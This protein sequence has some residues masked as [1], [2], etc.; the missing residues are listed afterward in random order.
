MSN[1]LLLL[2][3][4]SP[5]KIGRDILDKVAFVGT[6]YSA[7]AVNF[8][9][10]SLYENLNGVDTVIVYGPDL[11]GAGDLI[12]QALRGVCNEAVRVPCK[13]VENLGVRVVDLRWSSEDRLRRAVEELYKP[14]ASEVRPRVEIQLEV[15][16]KRMP[17]Q[18]PHIL[19]DSDLEALRYKAVDYLLTY[20]LDSGDVIYGVLI[21]QV[22]STGSYLMRPCDVL[23]EWPCGLEKSAFLIA[24][25]AFVQ[26]RGL[27]AFYT[28]KPEI[29]KR[30]VYDPHGNFVIADRLYHY[31]PR[32][33]LLRQLELDEANL[34]KEAQKLLP[35]HAFYLGQEWA[36]YKILRDRYVQDRWKTAGAGGGI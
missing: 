18:G 13:Y 28:A 26:K 16:N 29:Y 5:D 17:Y 9:V 11:N 21:L 15:P 12:I 24:T 10:K 22:G 35:D 6:A 19:Y 30:D 31:S 1:L 36:A 20:G 14:A 3:W 2:L 8:V 25:P 27:E 23:Q 7:D 32:G 34:R 33:V 4:Q